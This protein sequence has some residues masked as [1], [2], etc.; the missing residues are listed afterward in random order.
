MAVLEWAWIQKSEALLAQYSP[1][2]EA[3]GAMR[4]R[5]VGSELVHLHTITW[6]VHVM[7]YRWVVH[8]SA[9][10]DMHMQAG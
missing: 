2:E 9:A 7:E 3:L 4:M 5:L 1:A 10:W 6:N 8:V